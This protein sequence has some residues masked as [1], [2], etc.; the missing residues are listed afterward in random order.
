MRAAVD[1]KRVVHRDEG[2]GPVQ[3]RLLIEY[4]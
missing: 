1:L 3:V 2:V 4:N